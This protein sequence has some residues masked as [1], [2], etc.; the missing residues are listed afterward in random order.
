VLIVFSGLPGTG[1]T[2]L[3][4]SLA[5]RLGAVF[6]RI[7]V[8]EQA[9]RNAGVLAGDVGTAGYDV[10]LGLASANLALGHSVVA[11]CVNPVA[12]SRAAWRAVAEKAGVRLLDIE[13]VCSDVAEHRRRVETRLSDI[14]GLLVPNWESVCRHTY[15]PWETP[16][17]VLDTAILAPED[18]L[19]RI[20]ASIA[21]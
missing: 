4:R 8:I 20:E 18:A 5:T 7:D 16:I 3:A 6:L 11:D 1:K 21:E 17:L 13:V 10:A 9:I 2:T 14:P 12:A 15:E 19:L